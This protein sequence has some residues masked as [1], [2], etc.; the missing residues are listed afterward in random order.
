MYYPKKGV[1]HKKIWCSLSILRALTKTLES[2]WAFESTWALESTYHLQATIWWCQRWWSLP[3]HLL[4]H[5]RSH[6]QWR[7]SS[8][9][10]T[11]VVWGTTVAPAVSRRCM[12]RYASRPQRQSRHTRRTRSAVPHAVFWD[13]TVA[14]A[15]GWPCHPS[16]RRR[17]TRRR[18]SLRAFLT[19]SSPRRRSAP[20]H[21]RVWRVVRVSSVSRRHIHFPRPPRGDLLRHSYS[22]W[23]RHLVPYSPLIPKTPKNSKKT[24]PH[25]RYM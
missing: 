22:C 5:L 23:A 21:W 4:A 25:T 13:T 9:V 24:H 20:R 16:R 2:T 11:A 17:P 7:P 18:N 8:A 6:L 10:A 14:L 1:D 12:R 15:R 19:T 3:A